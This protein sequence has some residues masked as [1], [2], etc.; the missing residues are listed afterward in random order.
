MKIYTKIGILGLICCLIISG[1]SNSSNLSSNSNNNP[2]IGVIVGNFNDSWRTS[3]RNELYKMAQ[4]KYNVDIWNANNSQVTENKK[5]DI[6]IKDKVNVLAV[7]LVESSAASEII[8]KAKKVNIPIV[9]FNVEPSYKDLKKWDKVY[10]VGAR[11]EQSGVIQA[12]ILIDYFK[13]HPTGDGTIHYV[14]IK[15]PE[16]HQDAILRTKYSVSTMENAGFK[17][18]KL[19]EYTALWDRDK[20]HEEMDSFISS[21]NKADCIIA[22]NDDMALGAID[23]LKNKGYFNGGSY[24]PV[25]GVDATSVAVSAVK[26]GVLLGTVLNDAQGQGEA[27]YDLATIL[28]EGKIP[29][30]QNFKN[31]IVDGKYIWIDY[32]KVTN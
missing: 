9:F 24:M 26:S 25:V 1:C 12:N 10:Y 5:I 29:N 11:A 15:G 23:A 7:N 20:A 17:M 30:K 28:G 4:G 6:L 32:K 2:V 27:I 13:D 3:L 22:N 14:M 31:N 18:E 21:G 16:S 19:G 8:E